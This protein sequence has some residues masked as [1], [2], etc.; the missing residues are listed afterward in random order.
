MVLDLTKNDINKMVKIRKNKKRKNIERNL[1]KSV[2]KCQTIQ[3]NKSILKI[4][5]QIDILMKE[6]YGPPKT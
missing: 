5:F 6:R 2:D 1:R 4:D 3:Y